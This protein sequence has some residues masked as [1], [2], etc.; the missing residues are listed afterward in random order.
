MCKFKVFFMTILSLLIFSMGNY[1][2]SE[3]INTN[4]SGLG[5]E[6]N[7]S[8]DWILIYKKP[9]SLNTNLTHYY[10]EKE[11][12]PYSGA[13]D[14]IGLHRLIDENI[15]PK[16]TIF[17][18]AGMTDEGRDIIS[19]QFLENTYNAAIKKGNQYEYLLEE[20]DTFNNRLISRF[21]ASNGYDV[22]TVDYR[23]TY[24]P[25]GLSGKSL[26]FMKDWGWN[27]F[28]GDA[29][30]A[31]EKAKEVSNRKK[32]YLAGDSFGGMLTMNYTSRYW[33][34]DLLGFILLDGGNG[35]RFRLR[36]PLEVWKL[37][38]SDIINNIPELPNWSYVDGLTPKII[39]SLLNIF[40]DQ[41]LFNTLNMYSFDKDTTA[42]GGTT[43]IMSLI[44]PL[45]NSAGIPV[46]MFPMPHYESIRKNA[47]NNVLLPPT[48]PVTG[49]YLEPYNPETNKPFETY[50]EWYSLVGYLS[51]LEGLFSNSF[52]GTNTA[53][54][55]TVNMLNNTRHW[56]MKVLLEA[57]SMFEFEITTSNEPIDLL[58]FKINFSQFADA[59][60]KMI[61]DLQSNI[62]YKE[63]KLL[64]SE[65]SKS[66]YENQRY[67]YVNNYKNIDIP[68]IA[69]QS[70]LGLLG[71]GHLKHEIKNKDITD[72]GEYP[73]FGH[74]D[75]YT[76]FN[77][78][79]VNTKVLKWL[80]ERRD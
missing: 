32:V 37:I 80:N 41:I 56:P 36:I 75:I 3:V 14:K 40:G 30:E 25:E 57:I 55:Q 33:K 74:V 24:I 62:P 4:L 77:V 68:L 72:G 22:Y 21:L 45:L 1:L 53:L 51:P 17:V 28:V 27:F 49:I 48:D 67:D 8:K 63:L 76:G 12:P 42:S 73:E 5:K 78:E 9:L 2:E 7:N 26:S 65:S 16:A 66:L 71:W 29:K 15:K 35:G 52:N 43:D 59:F 60:S 34:D 23:T 13:Y 39:Q 19:D 11:M 61:K 69:F 54:G 47:F 18:L 46:N 79:K 50:L 70:R 31:V 6:Q 38:E 58:G 64:L 20:I 44:V 10:W